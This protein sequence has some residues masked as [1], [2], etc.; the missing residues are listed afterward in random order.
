M[1][2][3]T[4]SVIFAAWLMYEKMERGGRRLVYGKIIF[5]SLVI[6]ILGFV[7]YLGGSAIMNGFSAKNA[8]KSNDND[9][10]N[11]QEKQNFIDENDILS[12]ELS[13]LNKL[14]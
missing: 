5:F 6:P 10:Y 7:L 14:L 4:F 9:D 12:D 1:I 3:G 13:K 2:V 8:N 11:Y